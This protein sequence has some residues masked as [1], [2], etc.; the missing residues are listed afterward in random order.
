MGLRLGFA[1]CH[2]GEVSVRYGCLESAAFFK[3]S[4]VLYCILN[5][6]F[7]ASSYRRT[8]PVWLEVAFLS[9]AQGKFPYVMAVVGRSRVC[10]K[11]L[12]KTQFFSV[13]HEAFQ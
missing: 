12:F 5:A 3:A 7:S 2:M 10:A 1:V 6:T 9:A 8:G 4:I 11:P 13:W